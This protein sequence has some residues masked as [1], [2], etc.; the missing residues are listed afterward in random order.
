MNEALV[1][2]SVLRI[3]EVTSVEGRKVFIL[4]DSEKNASDLLLNGDI[5][6]N[7][8]VGAYIE[9]RKGFMSLIGKVDGERLTEVRADDDKFINKRILT[10]SLTG[11]LDYAKDFTGGIK[12]L[13][14]I[15]NEA[16]ILT[17]DKV[18]KIHTLTKS[19]TSHTINIAETD[20]EG[21]P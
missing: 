21:I 5:I 4:V 16:F 15:G 9:I 8:S 10:V 7:I 19:T 2:D 6:K 11:F 17:E 1:R 14:L 3:G 12:E 18:Q 13:P 20:I